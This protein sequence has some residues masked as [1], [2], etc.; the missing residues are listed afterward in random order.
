MLQATKINLRAYYNI[1][2]DLLAN[3]HAIATTITTE[4][5]G[6]ILHLNIP[7]ATVRYNLTADSM[8]EDVDIFLGNYNP[9]QV[10]CINFFVSPNVGNGQTLTT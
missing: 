3:M 5:I 9:I 1:T 10:C 4:V 8:N 6:D 7:D 2:V